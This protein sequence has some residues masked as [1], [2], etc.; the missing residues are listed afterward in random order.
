MVLEISNYVFYGIFTLEMFIKLIGL[1][2][3]EYIEDK[4]NIFD[5]FIILLNTVDIALTQANIQAGNGALSVFRGFRVLRL[6]KLVKQWTT[7]R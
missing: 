2:L 4:F 3:K 1:G 6:L 7:L 5:S